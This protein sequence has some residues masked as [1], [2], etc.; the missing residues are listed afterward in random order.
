MVKKRYDKS[1]KVISV[2]T[3]LFRKKEKKKR[4]ITYLDKSINIIFWNANLENY[5][6]SFKSFC[7]FFMDILN[8]GKISQ[9]FLSFNWVNKTLILKNKIVFSIS[10]TCYLDSMT[11]SDPSWLPIHGCDRKLTPL[12]PNSITLTTAATRITPYSKKNDTHH[13]YIPP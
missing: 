4:I 11:S 8:F 2:C 10:L 1:T 7:L 12:R 6:W 13:I 3:L 9:T 5:Q